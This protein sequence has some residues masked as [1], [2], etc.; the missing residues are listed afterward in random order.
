VSAARVVTIPD[1]LVALAQGGVSLLVATCS[2][3][4]EPS[5]TRAVGLRIWPGA[6]QVTVFLAALTSARCVADL[7]SHP[8][9]ALTVCQMPTHVTFQ[10]KGTARAVRVATAD[11][12]AEILAYRARFA[13]ELDF[14]GMPARTGGRLTCWPAFAVDVDLAD[15]FTQTPGP[16]AGNRLTA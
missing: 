8:H 2:A 16:G 6:A 5:S 14:L 10:I 1:H 4:L 12:R 15:V 3:E 13:A 9:I 11:E 7:R